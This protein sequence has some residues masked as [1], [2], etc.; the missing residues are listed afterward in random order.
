MVEHKH[1]RAQ[2]LST[3]KEQMRLVYEQV[4]NSEEYKSNEN[5]PQQE[6]AEKKNKEKETKADS[7]YQNYNY[8]QPNPQQQSNSV[9]QV[10]QPSQNYQLPVQSQNELNENFG[11]KQHFQQQ[12]QN[13]LQHQVAPQTPHNTI[14]SLTNNQGQQN[15][16]NFQSQQLTQNSQTLQFQNQQQNFHPQNSNYPH[17]NTR[18]FQQ[19][20][21]SQQVSYLPTGQQQQTYLTQAASGQQPLNKVEEPRLNE[22]QQVAS[23]VSENWSSSSTVTEARSNHGSPRQDASEVVKT[24]STSIASSSH[25]KN[26]VP[27]ETNVQTA[28]SVQNVSTN[29][30]QNLQPQNS[31]HLRRS[32]STS[33]LAS[34]S[35][36]NSAASVQGQHIRH[37]P[38][39]TGQSIANQQHSTQNRNR[40]VSQGSGI[41]AHH[42]L[43]MQHKIIEN[44]SVPSQKQI[45]SL[46][47]QSNASQQAH[48]VSTANIPI[49]LQKPIVDNQLYK[50]D[51]SNQDLD[52]Q[53]K[54]I[55][56]Q[57]NK[58]GNKLPKM[59]S[60]EAITV[61]TSL[62]DTENKYDQQT[63]IESIA[64]ESVV[65]INYVP[66]TQDTINSEDNLQRSA[67][68]I[69]VDQ[70]QNQ[71]PSHQSGTEVQ[72][73]GRFQIIPVT[74][75]NE[76]DQK[77]FSESD[78]TAIQPIKQIGRFEITAASPSFENSSSVPLNQTLVT[79]QIVENKQQV[80]PKPE[81]HSTPTK[82]PVLAR[83]G[84]AD[85]V[86]S[87]LI[88]DHTI[89]DQRHFLNTTLNSVAMSTTQISLPSQFV[90]AEQVMNRTYVP[91]DIN[92][93]SLSSSIVNP[94]QLAQPSNPYPLNSPTQSQY[95]DDDS[96]DP[97]EEDREY[98][99]L[100]KRLAIKLCIAFK[101]IF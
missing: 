30:Q 45:E 32:P 67:S 51:T 10:N 62:I 40:K 50:I 82:D 72:Q 23:S 12:Q 59:D 26:K 22:I 79:E 74:N 17:V 68:Q 53:L 61:E 75:A 63:D 47:Q 66:P 96:D 98:K 28:P 78:T 55:M 2:D 31:T 80:P 81:H 54:A 1:L 70:K 34:I 24:D 57:N 33:S 6:N 15:Q 36:V 64:G 18:H 56:S 46:M 87:P 11:N 49:N 4:R 89:Q 94:H 85:S 100:L 9:G 92:R 83:D 73:T 20:P 95:G 88:L 35:S 42:E 37:Y 91:I 77:N 90:P 29:T 101:H 3:F 69:L 13:V 86:S 14:D 43:E 99:E 97:N 38:S 19:N 21:G 27:A 16:Q 71:I 25:F 41:N 60:K 7:S 48:P 65:S 39:Q 58:Q 8:V 93:Q 52:K 44:I 84:S 76:L 5:S